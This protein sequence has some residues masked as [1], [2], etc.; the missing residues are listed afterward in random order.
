MDGATYDYKVVDS[1]I[2][3][4]TEVNVLDQPTDKKEVTLITCHPL[5]TGT[6]RLIIKGEL[7]E[8]THE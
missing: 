5:Y 4:P 3:E 1:L 8:N 6:H 2:V 7:I